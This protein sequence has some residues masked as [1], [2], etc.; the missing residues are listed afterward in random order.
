MTHYGDPL[1]ADP[2]GKE[3]RG[4]WLAYAEPVDVPGEDTGWLVIVQEAYKTAIG[5]TLQELKAGLLSRGLV[6]LGLVVILMGSL[7]WF[8]TRLS[9]KY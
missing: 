6:A 8:A 4:R 5:S 9:V 2:E 7:W 3:Y 1:A